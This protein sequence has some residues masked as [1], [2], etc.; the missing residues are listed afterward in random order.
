MKTIEIDFNDEIDHTPDGIVIP[1]KEGK[2]V[3]ITIKDGKKTM[4]YL[5]VYGDKDESFHMS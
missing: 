4:L 5:E 1:I 2:W 3:N